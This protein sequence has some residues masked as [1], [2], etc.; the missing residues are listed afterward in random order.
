[1]RLSRLF[2]LVVLVLLSLALL[3]G[4]MSA[5]GTSDA[6]HLCQDGGYAN[7]VGVTAGA[8]TFLANPGECVNFAAQGGQLV[9]IATVQPC[10]DGGMRPTP[11]L[12]AVRPSRVRR[13]V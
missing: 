13:I 4:A 9:A 6:A 1:M 3:P 7:Y 8:L 10:L 5:Q 12:R 2:S 11:R